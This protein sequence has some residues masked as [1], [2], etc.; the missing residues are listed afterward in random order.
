MRSL[1]ELSM[2]TLAIKKRLMNHFGLRPMVA[3][4]LVD[5]Q[6]GRVLA[7]FK[8]GTA[9]DKAARILADERSEAR[10][11]NPVSVERALLWTGAIGAT[12]LGVF[13][14]AKALSQPQNGTS[15]TVEPSLNFTP[16]LTLNV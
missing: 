9:A 15:T 1:V 5:E 2:Y 3:M 13:F 10:L 7:W 6:R 4:R 16:P 14:I 12:A 8:R 11:E